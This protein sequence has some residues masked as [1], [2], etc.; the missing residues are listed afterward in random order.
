MSKNTDLVEVGRHDYLALDNTTVFT[1][2]TDY[3]PATKKYVDDNAGGASIGVGQTWQVCELTDTGALLLDS[4]PSFRAKNIVY[5]N[6]T[7]MPIQLMIYSWTPGTI[8]MHI[9]SVKLAYTSS[10]GNYYEQL[11]CPIIPAG[12]TYE[13]VSTGSLITW[14]ELR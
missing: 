4:T 7:G 9:D 5:T 12:S 2:S 1:P 13:L 11:Y 14:S 10:G 3:E 6:S 8:E